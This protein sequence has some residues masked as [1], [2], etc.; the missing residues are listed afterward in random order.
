MPQ[1]KAHEYG[2][3]GHPFSSFAFFLEK[4]M[5]NRRERFEAV[6]EFAR[7]QGRRAG[8]RFMTAAKSEAREH[9]ARG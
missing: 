6:Q 8:D 5:R 3:L 1:G 7:A 4:K 9:P 2:L